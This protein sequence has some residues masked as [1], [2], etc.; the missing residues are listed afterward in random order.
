[1]IAIMLLAPSPPLLFMG[2]EWAAPEPFLFFCDFHD[3]LAKA[4]REGRRR[5][6]ARF[7][8]FA[9]EAARRKIPDPNSSATF[10]RSRLDWSRIDCE[11]NARWLAL[12]RTLLRL[13]QREIAPRLAGSRGNTARARRF[14]TG[15]LGVTWR[16][17]DGSELGLL[18]NL[19]PGT[20]SDGV[21]LPRGRLLYATADDLIDALARGSLPP[22]SAA[23][24]LA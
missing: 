6:F 13:R 1:M 14:G 2:E 22:W 11:A 5:E 7:P 17:G 15:G 23:W 9:D 19:A 18:A 24:F 20:C 21:P 16:L 4:V 3:D 10:E 12:Y 8:E